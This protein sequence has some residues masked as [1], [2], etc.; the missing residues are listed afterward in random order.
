MNTDGINRG[1]ERILLLG[2]GILRAEIRWIIE[3]NG[4][5]VDVSFLDSTLHIDFDALAKGL[6]SALA[7]K[8]GRKIIV[9]YG[10]CHPLMEKILND[11][12]VSRI[13]GQNCVEMLLGPEM[14]TG[15]LSQGAF[16]L[17]KDWARRFDVILKKTM[18]DHEEVWKAIYQGDRKYLACIR[19]PCSGDF[20]AEA[21]EAGK[22]V[23]LPLK[24][25]D[26]SLWH[27]ES[28]LRAA[29][30]KN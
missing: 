26:V 8:T 12:K 4:W 24:W 10:A 14:F 7:K 2:C 9:F 15:E 22:K 29:L 6:T 19:T 5:P 23:G 3:K 18:G 28:V 1:E 25:L 11:A 27:L 16:F 21:A 30:E 13:P 20:Q 17:L